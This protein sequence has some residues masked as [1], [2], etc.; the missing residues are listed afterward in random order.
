M[1]RFQ[2]GQNNNP[3]GR[4]RGSK[5]KITRT[6]RQ[7]IKAV[8]ETIDAENPALIRDAFEKGLKSGPPK[9]FAYLQLYAH[10]TSG[11]PPDKLVLDGELRIP[12]IVNHYSGERPGD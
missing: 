2:K 1:L 12:T 11:K 5:N 7:S 9:S 4:P 6:I 3:K 10:Y 8:C